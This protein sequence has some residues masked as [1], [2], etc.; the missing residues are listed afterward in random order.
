[1]NLII[2]QYSGGC[3]LLIFPWSVSPAPNSFP[4]ELSSQ[5]GP[6]SSVALPPFLSACI[7]VF[8]QGLS[9]HLMLWAFSYF[10]VTSPISHPRIRLCRNQVGRRCRWC[11]P[12]GIVWQFRRWE[13]IFP[14][15]EM[16]WFRWDDIVPACQ[17]W[18][19]SRTVRRQWGERAPKWN[20]LI[21]ILWWFT[22]LASKHCWK[23]IPSNWPFLLDF[24]VK[25]C[26]LP[27]NFHWLQD[28]SCWWRSWLS[29]WRS[30]LSIVDQV[31][32]FLCLSVQTLPCI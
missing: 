21:T 25:S 3:L 30:S 9:N 17:S 10:P 24:S 32:T 11:H 29:A 27:Q 1:M 8:W 18:C 19:H 15:M 12:L 31:Y 26:S 14:R 13:M 20:T 6:C 2:N 7:L 16:H 23:S 5:T 22:E 28:C 4:M